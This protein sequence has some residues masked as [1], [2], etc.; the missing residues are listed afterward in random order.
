MGELCRRTAGT[1]LQQLYDERIRRPWGIDYFL[2]LPGDQEPRYREVLWAPEPDRPW[3]DPL[4]LDGLT[5]NAPVSSIMELP[6]HRPS[7]VLNGSSRVLRPVRD[8]SSC[9]SSL[10]ALG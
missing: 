1:P 6:N 4:S 7:S 8:S 10:T 2:G 9:R 5:S 3:L